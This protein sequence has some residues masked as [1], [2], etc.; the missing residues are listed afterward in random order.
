M[1]PYP[2]SFYINAVLK[3]AYTESAQVSRTHEHHKMVLLFINLYINFTNINNF[4][5][6]KNNNSLKYYTLCTSISIPIA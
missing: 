6:K 3:N 5:L 1:N 2:N 4:V